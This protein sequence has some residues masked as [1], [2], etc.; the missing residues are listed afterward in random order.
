MTIHIHQYPALVL[1]ADFTP[2]SV[3]PLSVLN[4][5]DAAR[6]LFLEKYARVVDY[7]D[8]IRTRTREY[9]F[10]SVVAMKEYVPL[11]NGVAFNRHNIWIRDQGRCAYCRVPLK[12]S[13]FT[14]DHV[15]PRCRGGETTWDNIV[16]ACQPCNTRKGD[17]SARA[18]GLTLHVTPH[19]PTAW[20]IAAK[21]R[22]A[23][24][25][26]PTPREWVDFLY[27]ES[28]LER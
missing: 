19:Q 18:A 11:T 23:G 24:G 3:F 1:N 7:P 13:E 25:F 12:L 26:E 2:K 17:K 6:G 28:E 27:W 15:T 20:E 21:A 9:V 10:P 22:R 8:S 5:Q 4:W 14:F 16:C